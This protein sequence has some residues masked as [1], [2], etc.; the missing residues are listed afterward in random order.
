MQVVFEKSCE[1]IAPKSK[2]EASWSV[3][4][5]KLMAQRQKK[6]ACWKEMRKTELQELTQPQPKNRGAENFA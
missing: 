6:V 4:S 5:K 2:K 1:T 3:V